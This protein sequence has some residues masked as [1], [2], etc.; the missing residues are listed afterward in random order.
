MPFVIVK[1][2]GGPYDDAAFAAGMTCGQFWTELQQLS[3]HGATPR[4]RY[5]RPEHIPQLDLIAMHFNYTIKAGDTDE[6]SGYQ[7]I[8]FGPQYDGP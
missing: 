6:A 8:D 7:R 1:S 4:P 3:V 2:Q 5:V